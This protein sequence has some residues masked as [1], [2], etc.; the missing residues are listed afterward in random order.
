M[1]SRA[2][3]QTSLLSA[4]KATTMMT[5]WMAPDSHPGWCMRDDGLIVIATYRPRGKD[6]SLSGP[7]QLL[8]VD[9]GL[10]L[11]LEFE[12][13]RRL[14]IEHAGDD[15]VRELLDAHVVDVHRFVVELA[16]VGDA[17]FK[18]RDPCLQL[19]EGLVG[20]E[21]GV[22]LSQRKETAECC[23]QRAFG[24]SELGDVLGFARRKH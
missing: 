7:E 9:V 15:G 19:L 5:K 4:W 13:L 10:L 6:R 14:E 24:L 16:P 11:G 18:A 17:V 3:G 8:D 1:A 2:Y 20:L 22:S 12:E 23:A 21:V